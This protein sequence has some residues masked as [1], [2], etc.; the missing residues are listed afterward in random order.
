MEL[1]T[2]PRLP[3]SRH[4]HDMCRFS[5][6]DDPSYTKV[7]ESLRNIILEPNSMDHVMMYPTLAPLE[8]EVLQSLPFE[9]A[10]IHVPDADR[11]TCK[12]LL[13]H[14]TYKSWLKEPSHTLWL[15]GKPGSGKTVLMK[16]LVECLLSERSTESAQVVYYFFHHGS[17]NQPMTG[18]LTSILR[19][20][21]L[22]S[23]SRFATSEVLTKL[24]EKREAQGSDTPW[25]DDLLE[26]CFLRLVD[27]SAAQGQSLYIIVDALDECNDSDKVLLLLQHLNTGF[28]PACKVWTCVSSRHSSPFG[29]TWEIRIDDNNSFC[30]QKY[31]NDKIKK[32]QDTTLSRLDFQEYIRAIVEKS[33]GVFLWA[34]LVVSDL[35][36]NSYL[37]P[38]KT[39]QELTSCLPNDLT[40]AYDTTLERL[41]RSH[42]TPRRRLALDALI[43]VVCAQRP[44]SIL[45]LN[46]ALA[47]TNSELGHRMSNLTEDM[48]DI[49]ASLATIPTDIAV[50]L[51]ILCGG[52]LKVSPQ[53][54]RS[55]NGTITV[56]GSK[57]L[58]IHETFR[59]YLIEKNCNASFQLRAAEICL[60][61]IDEADDKLVFPRPSV[62][63]REACS[64]L[65][66]H[67]ALSCG[68][69][70]LSLASRMG[71]RPK[72]EDM[73]HSPIFQEKFV[74]RWTSCHKRFFG[75]R[76]RFQPGKTKAAHLMSYFGLPW[77]ETELWGVSLV[78]INE[79]D[80]YGQ[81]PLSLAAAMGHFEVCQT[82][83]RLGA[84]INHRDYIY[85]QTAL[86]LAAAHGHEEIVELLLRTGSNLYDYIGGTS[87]L[88]M[89]VRSADLH[90]VQLILQSGADVKMT[91]VQTGET[92]LSRAAA[93]G[94]VPIVS[95]L[96]QSGAE[97]ESCDKRGWTPLHHAVSHGR[98]KTVEVLI[99]SLRP[100]QLY[101]LKT[102]HV[103]PKSSW[104]DA[105][106]RAI[107][108]CL[109][110]RQC[111]NSGASHSGNPQES[112]TP[113][114]LCDT[115]QL[116]TS[117]RK[118]GRQK[119][120][121]DSEDDHEEEDQGISEK[122]LRH[123]NSGVRR[124]ACPYHKRNA[125]KYPDGACNGKGFETIHRLKQHLKKWHSRVL[126]WQRCHICKVRFPHDGIVGH[127]PCVQRDKP[128][129]YEEGYDAAQLQKLES[130]DLL[131]RRSSIEK[132]WY[133]IF[134]VLFPD[135][136]QTEEI[137][138]PCEYFL[139]H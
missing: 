15:A 128:S 93:I 114:P 45:E 27:K 22:N 104:V 4:H 117:E 134:K 9:D 97:V 51:L 21:L 136:P 71:V 129:D 101:R 48:G 8:H 57:V 94:H 50:Q 73:R 84:D 29:P 133:G 20:Q 18:F 113:G 120:T 60:L 119:L 135:W 35:L 67:Y 139:F 130:K 13:E 81:T 121:S 16:Y 53:V 131:P 1:W 43:L 91:N 63:D 19:Q 112:N 61:F 24:A 26:E 42:T 28:N 111:G 138:S 127:S 108:L 95:L 34:A 115:R 100:P 47:V 106:F 102:G 69:Q 72:E 64:P 118:R 105:V 11:G 52:L 132:C 68:M 126:D 70:H 83:I 56:I 49:D 58:L 44:L 23:T 41:Y 36:R 78:E 109:Y 137:P 86:S 79:K 10:S 107:I 17:A 116:M 103:E 110:F 31:L 7:L 37:K 90:I 46:H 77:L 98:K 55:A 125:E 33:Q 38:F 96:L 92:A 74:D 123:S 6:N 88:L 5:S 62:V 59:E 76:S 99:E 89:A 14:D 80:H 122:R 32:W 12:W 87:T 82:L 40:A 25:D 2:F 75:S 30:I 124:I 85:G 54:S 3:L 39:A 66:L 65:F